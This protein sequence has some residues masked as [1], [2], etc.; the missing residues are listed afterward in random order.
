MSKSDQRSKLEPISRKHVDVRDVSEFD[1]VETIPEVPPMP[2]NKLDSSYNSWRAVAEIALGFQ[3][4]GKP[5]YAFWTVFLVVVALVA[6]P[7]VIAARVGRPAAGE[8]KTLP[9]SGGVGN[10][11]RV[12]QEHDRLGC[13]RKRAG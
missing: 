11:G 5:A 9:C 8:Q 13:I 7:L 6:V 1:M 12:V 10:A 3:R 2:P 4:M